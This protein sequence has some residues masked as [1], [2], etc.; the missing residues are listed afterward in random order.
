MTSSDSQTQEIREIPSGATD[1]DHSVGVYV[2]IPFCERVCPYCDFAVVAARQIDPRVEERYVDALLRELETRR[3]AF[4]GRQL[5]TVYFGGGTPSLFSPDSLGRIVAAARA[6]FAS[7]A[8]P[9]EVTLEMN[10][11]TTERA[12]LAAFRSV[13]INRLSMGIQSFDD[14]TLKKLGRAHKAHESHAMIEAARSAGFENLSLDLILAC[15]GQTFASFERDLDA[16]LAHSPEHLSVY[17]LTIESG[18][19]FALANERG[20]LD[21]P[22]EDLASEMLEHTVLS[23]AAAG[24]ERYEVSNFAKPGFESVHNRRYWE[25]SPVL[26]L[27]MGAWSA[28][29]RGGDMPYG[30][31][32]MNPRDLLSYLAAIEEG[33]S[34][35]RVI[36]CLN[37]EQ[38]RGEAVFL[39]LRTRKGLNARAF[40]TEFG[41][42]PRTFYAEQIERLMA[43]GL[44]TETNDGGLCLTDRGVLLSDTVFTDFV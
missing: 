26:G 38:A 22:D 34:D 16:A 15:P 7:E 37:E 25:R 29:V 14:T 6:A 35:F 3:H 41:S 33:E 28:E 43:Q 32:L 18:T 10:P 42:P 44:M 30:G 4:A 12:R 2:H 19:P 31:R 11:S 40:E 21:R 5:A 13:G 39:G 23:G 20:Q 36:D 17:E 8:E 27:G 24:V 1:A 9:G